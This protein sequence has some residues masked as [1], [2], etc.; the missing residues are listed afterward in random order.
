MRH[1]FR[2]APVVRLLYSRATCQSCEIRKPP[3]L[4]GCRPS[5]CRIRICPRH[6]LDFL[7]R[8]RPAFCALVADGRPMTSSRYPAPQSLDMVERAIFLLRSLP[9]DVLGRRGH[10]RHTASAQRSLLRCGYDGGSGAGL[11]GILSM[12]QHLPPLRAV[13]DERH[14]GSEYGELEARVRSRQ[15]GGAEL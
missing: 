2:R 8:R 7:L 4:G 3:P 14:L 11:R 1:G 6:Q 10:R 15:S 13:A 5:H 12:V 9:A